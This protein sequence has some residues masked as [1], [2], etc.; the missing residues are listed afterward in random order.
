MILWSTSLVT[1]PATMKAQQNIRLPA[2]PR[3]Q[4]WLHWKLTQQVLPLFLKGL[5]SRPLKSLNPCRHMWKRG[6]VVMWK[7]MLS[8]PKGKGK[9]RSRCVDKGVWTKVCGHV[10]SV[11]P[12]SPAMKLCSLST[13]SNQ[14]LQMLP[15]LTLVPVQGTSWIKKLWLEEQ[16]GTAWNTQQK[17][18]CAV[19]FLPELSVGYMSCFC[20]CVTVPACT[21]G[22]DSPGTCAGLPHSHTAVWPT[23]LCGTL[24]RLA[25]LDILCATRFAGTH[26]R[27]S[28]STLRLGL[29]FLSS[30]GCFPSCPCPHYCWQ[31]SKF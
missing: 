14:P 5:N 18:T 2:N 25:T 31:I 19:H 12:L 4:K 27:F 29:C 11:L 17:A 20:H 16:V 9:V 6:G 7:Q 1:L 8:V 3:L 24:Y 22:I 26:S 10:V 28:W 13:Q 30:A 21:V 23:E 15:V